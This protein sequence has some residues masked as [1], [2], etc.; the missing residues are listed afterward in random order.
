MDG[1]RADDGPT[2]EE[3]N[4]GKA[5][6]LRGQGTGNRDSGGAPP[7]SDPPGG[8]ARVTEIPEGAPPPQT[9]P[10]ARHENRDS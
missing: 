5:R 9:P 1:R 10:G 6:P 7:P 2:T 8:E 4:G 3:K